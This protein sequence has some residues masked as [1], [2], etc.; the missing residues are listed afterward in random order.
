M[1]QCYITLDW[2]GL[3]ENNI[4]AYFAHLYVTEK[5]KCCKYDFRVLFTKLFSPQLTKGSKKLEYYITLDWNGLPG[6][7]TQAF[8]AH[9]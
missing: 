6:T 8:C 1:L 3:P 2:S 7:Y 9:S 5:M 4:Q